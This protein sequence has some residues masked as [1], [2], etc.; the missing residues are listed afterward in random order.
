MGTD[1]NERTWLAWLAKVRIIIITFLLGIEL[2]ITRLTPTNVPVRLF[3]SLILLWYTI[4]V[5]YILLHS[6]WDDYR[7]QA[8]LQILSDLA[9]ATAAIYLS[10]GIDTYYNF[11]FPL[12]IIVASILLSRAWA[13]L[14]AA[15]AFILFGAI[16]ELSYFSVIPSY[17]TTHPDLKSL[18]AVIFINL[19]AYVAIAYLASRLSNILRAVDVELQDKSGELESLQALHE[20]IIHSISGGLI[21]TGLDG[22]ITLVNAAGGRLLERRPGDLLARPVSQLFLDRLPDVRS[23]SPHV[24][25]RSLAPSGREKTFAVAGSALMVPDRGLIG[26]VYTFD[27]LTEIR[28]LEREVRMRDRLAAVGRLAAAIAHE[29]RNPLSSMAGSVKVLAAIS[30][31]SDE[32]HLLVEIVTRESE[33]LNQIITD[34]LDYSREKRYEFARVDLV[35]LLEDTLT[36]LEN[37]PQPAVSSQNAAKEGDRLQIVRQFESPQAYAMADGD[38][39]KQVFWNICENA[40][41]AMPSGG[42]LTVS[43]RAAEGNWVVSFA[44]TGT[45]LGKQHLEK[46]FEPFQSHFPGGTGL[47]LAIV[48]QIVQAHDGKISVRSVSGQGAEFSVELKQAAGQADAVNERPALAAAAGAQPSPIGGKAAPGR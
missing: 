8:P 1:F 15:L 29:I 45:G 11:L 20:N 36:L 13:F 31:L 46:I 10:G 22:R 23:A 25:V 42:T 7:I 4:S 41:R 34:F 5:F 44:D 14:S 37:R 2:A 47:G 6:L 28:R 33:R 30:P 16:L 27:D 3:L 32:Q 21:T 26:F 24:E 40:V 12:I 17:S 18:Q 48:Y 43:V 38:K 19:F 39:M 35:S 9:F